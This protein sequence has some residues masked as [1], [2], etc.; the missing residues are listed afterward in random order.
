MQ[1]ICHFPLASLKKKGLDLMGSA[2][3]DEKII[4]KFANGT[5]D[6]EEQMHFRRALQV[7][8]SSGR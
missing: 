8:D 1:T 2:A 5:D 7:A 6:V 3:F 4:I